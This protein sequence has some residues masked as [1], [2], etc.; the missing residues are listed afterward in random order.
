[1]KGKESF[2]TNGYLSNSAE[3]NN[4][5]TEL[6]IGEEQQF[7]QSVLSPQAEALEGGIFRYVHFDYFA[8]IFQRDLILEA[9]N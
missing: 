2:K 8:I 7:N 3:N 9:E 5:A 4:V 1:M 6:G